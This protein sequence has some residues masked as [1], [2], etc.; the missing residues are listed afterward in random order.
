MLTPDYLSH[1]P[2]SVLA[3]VDDLVNDIQQDI[4]RR[5]AKAGLTPTAEW[6]MRRL[7]DIYGASEDAMRRIAKAAGLAEDEVRTLFKQAG[8]EALRID[9]AIYRSVGLSPI[10][11]AQSP[12][13]KAIMLQGADGA[14]A[15]LYNYTHSLAQVSSAAMGATID[16]AYVQIMSGA[17]DQN[18]AIR[19][20]VNDLARQGFETITYP[21]GHKSHVEAVVRQ[22]V[23]TGVNQS[24]AKLQ[25]A[26]LDEMDAD[27]VEVSSHAGARP[28]HAVWQGGVYSVRG[29]TNG[30]DDFADSTGY[31]TGDGLCGWGCRHSFFPYFE[32][33]SKRAFSDDPAREYLGRDNDEMYAES[34]T[35]RRYE[36]EVRASKREVITLNAGMQAAPDDELKA[37]L[38]TD[39]STASVKL[40]QRQQRLEDFTQTSGYARQREREMVAGWDQSVAMKASWAHRRSSV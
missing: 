21:S 19:R 7:A 8:V 23:T 27:L 22:L 14:G 13:L 39:F 18:T 31:G 32:G 40:K 4:A 28:T 11:L 38:W 16:R 1:V 25:L 34:Q 29:R 37:Q 12:V 15:R 6:Q 33:L 24:T 20:A 2:D 10:P 17:F 30:Y 26:R 5:I 35:M 3:I 9:D 36:R